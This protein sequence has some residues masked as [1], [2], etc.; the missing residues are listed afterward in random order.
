LVLVSQWSEGV[1]HLSAQDVMIEAWWNAAAQGR[2]KDEKRR[3]A[4]LLIY[5]AWDLW[6]ERSRHIFDGVAATPQHVLALIK[7]E[8]KLWAVACREGDESLVF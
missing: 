5:T 3:L 1:I 7:E 4:G 6:K 2:S 8:W